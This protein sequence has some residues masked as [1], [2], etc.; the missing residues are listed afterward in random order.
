MLKENNIDSDWQGT[1][2]YTVK[3]VREG[4]FLAV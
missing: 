2:G 3:E 4:L 1:A